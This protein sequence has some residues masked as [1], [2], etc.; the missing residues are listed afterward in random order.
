MIYCTFNLLL[1]CARINEL[2]KLKLLLML[3]SS[4]FLVSLSLLSVNWIKWN[5]ILNKTKCRNE[6]KQIAN[7]QRSGY[8]SIGL[9]I[10]IWQMDKTIAPVIEITNFF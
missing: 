8:L 3:E 9:L 4:G 7:G 5:I 6:Y 1:S 10:N 2:L